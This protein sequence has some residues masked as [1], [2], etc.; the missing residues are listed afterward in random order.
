MT[1]AT[2]RIRLPV[3]PPPPEEGAPSFRLDR[4]VE[5]LKVGLRHEGS[6]RSWL[7]IVD[8]WEK[9][10]RDDG[11]EPVVL[12]A[13][14]RVGHEGEVTRAAVERWAAEIDCGVAGLGTCGSCTSNSVH[15]AVTL[16]SLGKPA[17]AA[18]C[19]EFETHGRNM[20]RFLGH[21]DL[22]VLVL[23]YPLEARPA[24]E[25]HQIALDHYPRFLELLGAV[26]S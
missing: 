4:P 11:A 12:E 19:D 25:L 16:E 1:T 7:L 22:Q 5:G 6:W 17:V 8:V 14:G 18:V 20:A 13:G 3:A 9:L 23:P 21:P 15:D 10:L 26:R 24:H 2:W